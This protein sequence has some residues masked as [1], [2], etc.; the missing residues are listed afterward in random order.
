[1]NFSDDIEYE[2]SIAKIED[3]WYLVRVVP[4]GPTYGDKYYKCD[5]QEGLL[6]LLKDLI[7]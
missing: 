6:K 7:K 4:I 5:Q 1:M 2:I 3:E